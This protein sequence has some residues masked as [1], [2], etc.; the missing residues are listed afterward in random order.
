MASKSRF[1]ESPRKCGQNGVTWA[2]SGAGQPAWCGNARGRPYGGFWEGPFR[3]QMAP[4]EKPTL[5][6]VGGLPGAHATARRLWPM[7]HHFDGI[8]GAFRGILISRLISGKNQ[9]FWT[10]SWAPDPILE[11]KSPL[12]HP[13][14]RFF[15]D[16]WPRNLDSVKALGNA[17]R[18]V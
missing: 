6:R 9:D 4:C 16:I 15:A 10:V 12:R 8:S 11:Q 13:E 1:R 18:M 17:V 2:A 3:A 5:R 14:V 7:L